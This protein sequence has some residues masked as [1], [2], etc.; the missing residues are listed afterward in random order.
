MS[1]GGLD[2]AKQ[3]LAR[4]IRDG[5]AR[6][7]RRLTDLRWTKNLLNSISPSAP[8]A[9]PAAQSGVRRPVAKHASLQDGLC[10]VGHLQSEIGLGQA[11]RCLAYAC[12]A[13]RLP[14]SFRNLPLPQRDNDLEFATKCNA[15]AD[16]K[17]SLY[18]A[19]LHTVVDLQ[20]EIDGDRVNILYPYWELHRA[21]AKW[22]A[23]A[24]R[25][26]EV[27][28][29]SVF[30]AGA[31]PQSFARPVR[32]VRQPVRLPAVAP[33]PTLGSSPTLKL[34]VFFDFDSSGARK[35]PVAAVNAFQTAFAPERRDVELIVKMRGTRDGGL[36][37]WLAHAAASDPRIH[38]IDR[39]LDRAG[40]DALI[41]ECDALIS[42][43]RS[44]GF[45]FGPVEAII[46]GKAV[47]ATDYGGTCDFISEKTGYPVDYAL[48][49]VRPGEYPAAENQ[50]WADARIDSAAAALQSI[51]DRPDEARAR[52]LAAFALLQERHAPT[53][54]GAEVGRLL[55]DLGAL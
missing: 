28:A 17:V 13:Q 15:L 12:D 25:F 36:R 21:P 43:H 27:W 4:S 9:H 46:A 18:V 19:A 55:R 51:Y 31:F 48:V 11:A 1:D 33:K 47:V 40:M 8:R 50:Q 42:L 23:A 10:I 49:P 16:R 44:E 7:V 54:V 22:I 45:G 3:R 41:S 26:D 38:L 24:G 29:P 39:T 5:T 14:V 34:L 37:Q 35:N 20:R 6:T 52:T 53:V 30:V 2:R 32:V